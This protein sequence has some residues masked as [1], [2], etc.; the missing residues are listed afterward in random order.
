MTRL[1]LDLPR[2]AKEVKDLQE[3][4]TRLQ[5]QVDLFESPQHLMQLAS[6]AEFSHLKH[7]MVKDIV[8][9]DQG[10]A[11][12]CPKEEAEV[13]FAVAPKLPLAVSSRH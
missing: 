8:T 6:L 7:P 13:P 12:G 2:L 4:N 1:R 3:G 10:L 11:F 5:Y 9:L